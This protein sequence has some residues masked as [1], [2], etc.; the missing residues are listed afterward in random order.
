[1]CVAAVCGAR[2]VGEDGESEGGDGDCGGL[3]EEGGR[4]MCEYGG[5]VFILILRCTCSIH[6]HAADKGGGIILY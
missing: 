3:C 4:S 6:S 1:M 2:G 5:R